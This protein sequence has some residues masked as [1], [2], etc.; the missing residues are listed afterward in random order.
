[1][2]L[3]VTPR[4]L[5]SRADLYHQLGQLTAAGIGLVEALQLQLRNPPLP[6]FKTP[7]SAIAERLKAGANFGEALHAAGTWLTA[8]DRALLDAGER[9]G[10]LP[11]TFQQLAAHYTSTAAILRQTISS[12]LYPA[13]LFHFA[14]LIFPLPDLV[15]TGNVLVFLAKTLAV[16]LP[17]YGVVFA[18]IHSMRGTHSEAWR[19]RMEILLHRVPLAGAARR[20][21]ALARLTSALEALISAGVTIIEAWQLAA[22]ASGSPALRHAVA[23]WRPRLAAGVTPA[24]ALDDTPQFPVLFANLYHT[25]EI[26]GT[27]DDTLR[28]LH[29]LYLD[30]GTRKLKAL[31]EWTP[32]IVY[33]LVAIMIAFKVIAF[34][35]GYFKS[36]GDAMNF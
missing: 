19:G 20:S 3:L 26:T 28:R 12:F 4:Q 11:A 32:K 8:F 31:A 9:S 13:F 16:L 17:L 36:I 24:G 10:R 15:L 5:A 21:L 2:P 29:A 25:G 18:L 27:L 22:E 34:Y 23:A 6:S 33:L 7:L 14:I 1:M 30:E 35:S